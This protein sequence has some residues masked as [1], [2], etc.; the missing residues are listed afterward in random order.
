MKTKLVVGEEYVPSARL[1]KK[2][3]VSTVSVVGVQTTVPEDVKKDK[4][5]ETGDGYYGRTGSSQYIK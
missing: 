5:R 1:P 3:I 4:T 2:L